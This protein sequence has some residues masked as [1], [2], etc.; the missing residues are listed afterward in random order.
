MNNMRKRILSLVLAVL[1]ILSVLPTTAFAEDDA[2]LPT[3]AT[4]SKVTVEQNGVKIVKEAEWTNAKDGK[5]RITFTISGGSQTTTGTAEADIVLVIDQSWSMQYSKVTY[6]KKNNKYNFN[7]R[8]RIDRLDNAK[9]AACKF[10]DEVLKMNGDG[11]TPVRVALVTYAK[12]DMS[13][14]GWGFSTD[15]DAIKNNIN[16]INIMDNEAN[17]QN[18]HGTNIQAGIRKAQRLLNSGRKDAKKFMVVLTDG[19][20]TFSYAFTTTAEYVSC[21]AQNNDDCMRGGSYS[22]ATNGIGSSDYILGDTQLQGY[23]DN[24]RDWHNGGNV[25]L[26]VTCVKH[27]KKNKVL[28]GV[29]DGASYNENATGTTHAIATLWEANQAKSA[30]STIYTIGYGI[31]ANSEIE[32]LM[33]S[34]ASSADK[35]ALA[36]DNLDAITSKFESIAKDIT[37]YSVNNPSISDKMGKNFKLT[38]GKETYEWKYDGELKEQQQFSFDIVLDKTSVTSKDA[39][40][41]ND[42]ATLTYLDANKTRQTVNIPDPELESHAHTVTYVDAG[43]SAD[44]T[45]KLYWW[46]TTVNVAPN[47]TKD[48]YDFAGWEVTG[49]TITTGA[50]SFE[51]PDNDVT[52]TA[53][54]EQRP[55]YSVT[56]QYVGTDKPADADD[57][58]PTPTTG[59]YANEKYTVAALPESEEGGKGDQSGTW[60]FDGW[61]FDEELDNEALGEYEI[62]GNVNLYGKW[63]FSA[64]VC[65]VVYHLDGE[66]PDGV[67]LDTETDTDIPYGTSY[68]TNQPSQTTIEGTKDGKKGTWAFSGWYHSDAYVG[69]SVTSFQVTLPVE[70]LYG[71]WTFEAYSWTVEYKWANGTPA[72]APSVPTDSGVY[73]NE[74][75]ARAVTKQN[76]NKTTFED[77]NKTWTFKGWDDGVVA[78]G[79]TTVTY[80]GTWTSELIPMLGVTKS[81]ID[82]EKFKWFKEITDG[83]KEDGYP[84]DVVRELLKKLQDANA[85]YPTHDESA[86]TKTY[87]VTAAD[88]SVTFAYEV[89]V[90]SN[91]KT[92]VTVTDEDAR[93]LNCWTATVSGYDKLFDVTSA[94]RGAEVE[95]KTDDGGTVYLFFVKTFT[96]DSDRN[97]PHTATNEVTVSDNNNNNEDTEEV[98]ITEINPGTG[99]F[100]DLIKKE[101]EITGEKT[102]PGAEFTAELKFN[103]FE[104]LELQ[105]LA[106]GDEK[107][108]DENPLVWGDFKP[109]TLKATFQRGLETGATYTTN[110]YAENGDPIQLDFPKAGVYEFELREKDDR[111]DGVVYDDTVYTLFVTVQENDGLLQMTAVHYEVDEESKTAADLEHKGDGEYVWKTENPI[112]FHNSIDTGKNGKTEK[113]VKV[114][115]QLN[116][117]DHVAYIMGYPDGNVQPEGQITRAEACTIFF[118]LLTESSRDY[119]FSRTNDYT[120]VKAGDWYNNAI[121][122]LSNAGIV[123]GYNDGTFRPNQPITRGEMAKIIANFAN[124]NKGTK[125]F[126]DLSGHWSKTYVEL[127]AGNGWIAGYPDG[128]FRPDQKITRAE[129]VT[130][131]NRVL[132]RVPAKESRLLSRSIMLT[133]PDNNPG[134]WYYI[135]IQEASNSHE[136]QRSVYETAGD[137]MWTKLI[138]NVDWTKLEK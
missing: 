37:K 3:A 50:T 94:E 134:D 84:T 9:K 110:F 96:R 59:L 61:Y 132:E 56:Y 97:F 20:P 121:S 74:A 118:R 119:Y 128:S 68:K 127:A 48:G 80:T 120:D 66:T 38:D 49:T 117:D 57:L 114:G 17:G 21:K 29:Y 69:G 40:K 71:K 39:L 103:K 23:Y 15:A 35:Y 64:D 46:G 99:S 14:S 18:L 30:G 93:Y 81:V 82:Q 104:E 25:Q 91:N 33:K 123:T 85:V 137:E 89:E 52:L 1:M 115:P 111:E 12:Q 7:E 19:N 125:S 4:G 47:P 5:A 24:D 90:T 109:I 108:E 138:E 51:M 10:V 130:M 60:S 53:K 105:K 101:L 45:E 26:D 100:D 63:T 112:V 77:D 42:G 11:Q 113:P 13:K 102:F 87:E 92:T 126:T 41:T 95:F 6:D 36:N 8:D 16:S 135:A 28:R 76:P 55:T 88:N 136:Y 43:N 2:S 116:R 78:E 32:T 83:V 22:I 86:N 75:A 133:F 73:K 122:T 124:L 67:M 62:S 27:E 106:L 65:S 98:I 129:T 79:S 44:Y 34:I 31:A 131:I 58:L 72:A 70:D 54:W 107:V